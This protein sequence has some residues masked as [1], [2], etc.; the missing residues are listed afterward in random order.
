[1]KIK[2]MFTICCLVSLIAVSTGTA[3]TEIAKGNETQITANESYQWLPDIYENTIVWEDWRNYSMNIY[4]YDLITST[5]TPITTSGS[6]FDPAIYGDRIVWQDYRNGSDIYLYNLTTST[7][8]QVTTDEPDQDSPD[9]Y[10]DIIVWRDDRNDAYYDLINNLSPSTDS[11]VRYLIQTYDIYMYNLSTSM[12]TQITTSGSAYS[13]A[14]YADR[15]VWADKRNGNWDIYLYNISTC[16]ETRITTN[17][18]DQLYPSI[19]GDKIVWTDFRN[20]NYDIYMYDLSTSTETQVT[21]S[22]YQ[23]A[24]DVYDGRIVWEANSDIYMY[25]ISTSTET[26][27]TTNESYQ[28][29]P[30]IY[31]DRIAWQDTRNGNYDIYM[32]TLDTAEND[33]VNSE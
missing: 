27:I 8:T 1:M 15:I 33:T 3:A 18:S 17:E 4:M 10:G 22:G 20:V 5:E 19:Y 12:E 32:F 29:E 26:L 14:I 7:E 2:S 31:G 30:A 11:D 23:W 24:P 13:P 21:T 16:R 25:D 9:I 28:Q 6:A